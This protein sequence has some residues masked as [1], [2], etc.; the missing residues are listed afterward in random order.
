MILVDILHTLQHRLILYEKVS[1]VMICQ[2][3]DGGTSLTQ[4]ASSLGAQVATMNPYHILHTAN[5]G[6]GLQLEG[7]DFICI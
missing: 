7:N 1:S 5:R 2:A 4:C 6:Q 3:L